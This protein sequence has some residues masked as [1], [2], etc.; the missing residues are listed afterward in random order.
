M[1]ERKI[2]GLSEGKK[3]RLGE[4]YKGVDREGIG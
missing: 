1:V 2:D 4:R 3:G